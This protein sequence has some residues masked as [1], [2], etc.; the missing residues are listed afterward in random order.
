MFIDDIKSD[1]DWRMSELASLKTI[2][3]RYN[4][5]N[6]HS[7]LL[8]K[9]AVPSIY[10]LWEGFVKKSFELY[11]GHI[12]SLKLNSSDIHINLFTHSFSTEDKL[13]LENPRMSFVKKKEFMAFYQ[14]KLKSEF[15]IPQKIPTKSNV[16]YKV[17][18]EI[19]E[20][21]NLLALPEQPYKKGLNKLLRFRNNI[22]HGD[23][24]ILV[25]SEDLAEFSKLINDLMVEIF[26]RIEEGKLNETFKTDSDSHRQSSESLLSQRTDYQNE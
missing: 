9:Y 11:A 12:N 25:K 4:L 3:V 22:A 2:P 18:N 21:F 20:K 19:L 24:S 23:I 13:A 14:N 8:I 7:E 6:H 1:I 10:A 26:G 15:T 17:I 5:L 16:D